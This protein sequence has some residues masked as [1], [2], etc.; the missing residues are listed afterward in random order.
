MSKKFLTDAGVGRA[1]FATRIRLSL[2]AAEM[3]LFWGSVPMFFATLLRWWW[4]TPAQELAVVRLLLLSKILPAST[5][6]KLHLQDVQG[7]PFL[8]LLQDLRTGRVADWMRADQVAQVFADY[9]GPM[10]DFKVALWT[11]IGLAIA[12][13][14][15]VWFLLRRTG[16]G[17]QDNTR[18]RGAHELVSEAEI[19]Q[20]VKGLG[21][22]RY[23]LVGL[24]LPTSALGMGIL[25][26]GSPGSGK[27]MAI[28][29]LM[30]QVFARKKKCVIYD[31]SGEFYQAHFRPGVDHFF[32][33]ALEGSVTWS[34]FGELNYSYDADTLARAFLPPL[35]TAN[36]GEFFRDAARALF[37][38]L[39][40]RLAQRGAVN[41]A[42][43][44]RA[45]LEMPAE[46]MDHLIQKSVAS[47]SIG[48]DSKQQR[49][50]V[51]SSI[52]IYLNGIA[53]VGKGRWTV[54]DWLAKDDDSR[55]FILNTKDTAAMFAPMYRLMLSVAFG[56]I[57]ARGEI[58]FEDRFWFFLDELHQLGDIQ[59]DEQL[60]TVRKFG[61]CAV[62]GLQ[63]DSQLVANM[64]QARA[65]TLM[66][67]L[68]TSL[69]LLAQE[70]SLQQREAKRLGELEVNTVNRNQA[71]AVAEARDGAGLNNL[72]SQ[73]WVVMPSEFGT[74]KPL[75]GYIKIMSEPGVF[76][77]YQSWN[78]GRWWRGPRRNAWKKRQ[79]MP[80]R[81]PQF[82][83]QRPK[84][85]LE[86]DDIRKGVA[87]EAQA[88]KAAAA[89]A[90]AAT[91]GENTPSPEAQTAPAVAS[92]SAPAA[93]GSAPSAAPG[94]EPGTPVR[95]SKPELRLVSSAGVASAPAVAP[96][97]A[98]GSAQTPRT[99]PSG[100][101]SAEAG[102]D[103]SNAVVV[104][105]QPSQP[106]AQELGLGQDAS[107]WSEI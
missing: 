80:P 7:A 107:P 44:A 53:A 17:A 68:N 79:D 63:S 30:L 37:S 35:G 61:V 101:G 42:D 86:L 29:D 22:S 55:L 1:M 15:F 9:P 62:T 65:D 91:A 40:A 51:L 104:V 28:H 64:G 82:L 27:S 16:T 103:A 59:L 3:C 57:A 97:P 99:V 85:G 8:L 105:T 83:L 6:M 78:Q 34:L 106:A 43:L 5:L 2:K 89:A 92:A 58:V 90:A 33:P 67:C 18:I 20:I 81:E 72:E 49:Q 41:T 71:L 23:K 100:L 52:A 4:S 73:K 93:A 66:N 75:T 46:E 98:P 102:Q 45:F 94:T 69:L 87:D 12:A 60:A 14:A 36:S 74:L 70:G 88:A 31:Y 11:A 10:H 76:V 13:Y 25:A 47:S 77:D 26:L 96:S 84:D 24:P 54:R 39:V 32:N 21:A 38:V 95:D 19:R 48:G 56:H 50:G